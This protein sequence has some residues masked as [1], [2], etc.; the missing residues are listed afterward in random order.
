MAEEEADA[1][2]PP[3]CGGVE[4]PGDVGRR[5]R[6]DGAQGQLGAGHDHRAVEVG[7]RVGQRCRGVGHR[8]GA[9]EDDVALDA[10]GAVDAVG[11]VFWSRGAVRAQVVDDR[12]PRLGGGVGGVDE[13]IEDGQRDPPGE[14]GAFEE[15]GEP[16]VEIGAGNEPVWGFDHSDGAAGV[17]DV[18]FGCGC[19]GRDQ[20]AGHERHHR[21]LLQPRRAGMAAM[22]SNRRSAGP[23]DI[24]G[25]YGLRG[26]CGS[27]LGGW[28]AANG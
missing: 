4:G 12:L 24:W 14:G 25:L 9:V 15:F 7:Q 1:V 2:R 6:A 13:R 27:V 17:G 16:A 5:I 8:V 21:A 20:C 11:T 28:A 26:S 10:V 19:G 3:A 23:W 18:N 22:R